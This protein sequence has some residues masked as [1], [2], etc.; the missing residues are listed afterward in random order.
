MVRI[1]LPGRLKSYNSKNGSNGNTQTGSRNSSP[2]RALGDGRYLILKTTVLRVR[3]KCFFHFMS[4]MLIRCRQEIL[5]QKTR[6][7][8]V[9]RYNKHE[10]PRSFCVQTNSIEVPCSQARRY[11][12]I[13]SHHYENTESGVEFLA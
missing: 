5:R 8:P 4:I 1:N 7:V 6:T 10:A 2:M 11:L 3:R 13:H 12:S 9:I